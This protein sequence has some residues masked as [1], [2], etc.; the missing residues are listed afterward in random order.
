MKG[1]TL[2][3]S[4]TATIVTLHRVSDPESNANFDDNLNAIS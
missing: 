1:N 3:R 4:Y 2:R